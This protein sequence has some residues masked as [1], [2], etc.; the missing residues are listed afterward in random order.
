MRVAFK[1]CK[2][3]KSVTASESW[4]VVKKQFQYGYPYVLALIVT[5]SGTFRKVLGTA[6]I[7]YLKG[8]LD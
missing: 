4:E 6:D 3:P 5:I 8:N 2:F 7:F 1:H